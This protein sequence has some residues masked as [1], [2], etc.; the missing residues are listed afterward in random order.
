MKQASDRNGGLYDR[1]LDDIVAGQFKSGQRLK[2]SELAER[3]ETS[4][5]PVREAL[6]QLQGEGFVEIEHNRGATVR[7]TDADSVRDVHEILQVLEPYFVSWYAEI[8]SPSQ[9]EK[10]KQIQ[11]QIEALPN[12]AEDRS[13]FTKLDTQFHNLVYSSHYNQRAIQ[14]WR[15]LRRNL[16]AFTVKIP[17]SP[18]RQSMVIDEH[19]ELIDAFNVH[20][21]SRAREVIVR[22]IAGAGDQIYKQLR[23]RDAD[24]NA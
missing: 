8:A 10:L 2:I 11:E 12:G 21:V 6:R 23:I 7:K 3:Y 5:N 17:L 15:T 9:I 14:L 1:M 24:S 13:E 16:H 20:D 22:H 19:R 4:T 18:R